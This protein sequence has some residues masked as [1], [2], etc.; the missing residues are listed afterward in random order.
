M[1]D[2]PRPVRSG[3]PW[4]A[5]A[6]TAATVVACG[7]GGG[8]TSDNGTLKLAMTDSPGCGYD[9]VWITVNKIRI[10]QSATANPEDGG[11]RELAIT[12]RKIDLL[13]LT[14]GALQELGSL[15]LP[16]GRYE[17]ARLVLSDA[18]LANSLVLSGTNNEIELR[19]PSAQTSGYKLKAHF[20]VTNN[21]V[22]DMVLDFDACKSIVRAGNFGNYNLKPVVAVTKR[23]STQIEG[24]VDPAIAS[25]VVVSTR[26]PD[27]QLRATVPDSTTGKFV[28]AYLP[29]NTNYTVTISGTG[30]TTAAVTGVP[31]STAI[32]STQLNTAASPILPPTS[33]TAQISGT[34]TDASTPPQALVEA[35][36]NAQQTLSTSQA[37]DV[38]W[39][40]VDPSTA[41]YTLTLPLAA[42]IRASYVGNGGPLSFTADSITPG[43][44]KVYGMAAGYTTQTTDPNV[45]LGAAGTTTTKNLVLAP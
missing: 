39:S 38:A 26:D 42:P 16:A 5:A 32:G 35:S 27:N 41:G 3:W 19:T 23:L 4:L 9:H 29:E 10:H 30:R 14:N 7:G 17:Q 24:Y 40:L 20:E 13:A 15:P 18:P 8:S 36:V 45:T 1:L 31:V 34:V 25:S 12:P 2:I 37:L 28:I 6:V 11:W 22:A 44:Y 21:Q 43:M 33:T